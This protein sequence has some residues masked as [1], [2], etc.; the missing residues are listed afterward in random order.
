MFSEN[1]QDKREVKGHHC[2]TPLLCLTLSL[3]RWLRLLTV[4]SE[5]SGPVFFPIS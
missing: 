2:R 5:K 1:L 4:S 3:A